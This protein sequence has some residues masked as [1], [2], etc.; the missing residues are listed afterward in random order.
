MIV[1]FLFF[2]F[3]FFS[4]LKTLSCTMI[5]WTSFYPIKRRKLD[6]KPPTL[7]MRG[8]GKLPID[9]RTRVDGTRTLATTWSLLFPPFAFFFFRLSHPL[10]LVFWPAATEMCLFNRQIK[11]MASFF[12]HRRR[13]P[14]RFQKEEYDPSIVSAGAPPSSPLPPLPFSL[15]RSRCSPQGP[16]SYP[17]LSL[18]PSLFAR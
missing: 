3:P 14:L 2:I 16:S 5:I 9:S 10:S 8:G 6:E 18:S 4:L 7:L 15:F 13:R 17:T 1:F 11:F 12:H